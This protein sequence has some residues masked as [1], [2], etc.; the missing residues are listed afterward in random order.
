MN[1]LKYKTIKLA[2]EKPELREEL[3]PL[4]VDGYKVA[5]DDDSEFEK[6]I[7]DKKFKNPETGNKVKFDSL[8]EKEQKK[9]RKEWKEK[10][11]DDDEDGGGKSKPTKDDV[12]SVVKDLKDMDKKQQEDAFNKIKDTI[13]NKNVFKDM[14]KDEALKTMKKTL[15]GMGMSGDD[16]KP[17]SFGYDEDDM[18]T[19]EVNEFFED[20]MSAS[21]DKGLD[22]IEA[23]SKNLP[24]EAFEKVLEDFKE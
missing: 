18:S 1:D 9:I 7:K 21:S 19:E 12:K 22:Q 14:D 2:Y 4:L 16:L 5:K 13:S 15:E 11:K 8:P 24:P 3:L 23:M 6:A 20:S 10:N 17:G